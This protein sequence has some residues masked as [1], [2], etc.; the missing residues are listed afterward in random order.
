MSDPL[1]EAS[2]PYA[3]GVEPEVLAEAV[4]RRAAWRSR[5]GFKLCAG[6]CRL[7]KPP[8]AFGRDSTRPD[9]LRAVCR[10]CRRVNAPSGNT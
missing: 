7:R 9:G 4:A 10:V 2:R 6:P 5:R 1:V 8:S 3:D